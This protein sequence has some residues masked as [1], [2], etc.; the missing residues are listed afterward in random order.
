MGS[1]GRLQQL[2]DTGIVFQALLPWL[3]E[4]RLQHEGFQCFLQAAQ[5]QRGRIYRRPCKV[6]GHDVHP[7]LIGFLMPNAPGAVPYGLPKFLFIPRCIV[8][9]IRANGAGGA[10]KPGFAF[11]IIMAG[12]SLHQQMKGLPR[13]KIIGQH[14]IANVMMGLLHPFRTAGAEGFPID[15]Q[16][17]LAPGIQAHNQ[18]LALQFRTGGNIPPEPGISPGAAPSRALRH[19]RKSFLLCFLRRKQVVRVESFQGNGTHGLIKFLLQGVQPVL[20]PVFPFRFHGI[21]PFQRVLISLPTVYTL[22]V[23]KKRGGTNKNPLPKQG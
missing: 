14:L 18:P 5:A 2:P 15:E 8:A 17:R 6:Q 13:L 21:S 3:L 16:S 10:A 4:I 11:G 23:P 1:Q 20:Q 9:L 19:G 22:F 7:Q 12:I